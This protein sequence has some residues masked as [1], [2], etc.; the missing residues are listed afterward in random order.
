MES[1]VLSKNL[2][3]T[4]KDMPSVDNRVSEAEVFIMKGEISTYSIKYL[5]ISVLLL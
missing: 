4:D 2:M 3:I 5:I 1:V